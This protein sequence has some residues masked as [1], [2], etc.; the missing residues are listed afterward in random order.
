MIN[1]KMMVKGLSPDGLAEKSRK[2]NRQKTQKVRFLNW[3]RVLPWTQIQ[4]GMKAMRKKL[5]LMTF[6]M[7]KPSTKALTIRHF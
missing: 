7:L 4:P 2:K 6:P 3:K 1:L 5:M